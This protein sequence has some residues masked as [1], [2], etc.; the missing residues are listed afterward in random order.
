MAFSEFTSE[1]WILSYPRL[2][3]VG[4]VFITRSFS[5]DVEPTVQS[6][7]HSTEHCLRG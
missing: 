5:A 1:L 6:C 2:H 4:R 3:G 7:V